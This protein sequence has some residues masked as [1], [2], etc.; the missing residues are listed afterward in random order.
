M[1]AIDRDRLARLARLEMIGRER[2]A[3]REAEQERLIAEAEASDPASAKITPAGV[4]GTR[5]PTI[6]VGEPTCPWCGNW[7]KKSRRKRRKKFSAG[8]IRYIDCGACGETFRVRS[9]ALDFY[10]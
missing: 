5:Y 9:F 4:G 1:S 7:Q 3:Q 8:F 6:D 10:E 2:I